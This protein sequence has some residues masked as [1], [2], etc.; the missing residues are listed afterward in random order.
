MLTTLNMQNATVVAW[1]RLT[2]P[3]TNYDLAANSDHLKTRTINLAEAMGT[4]DFDTN[5]QRDDEVWGISTLMSAGTVLNGG[6]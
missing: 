1:D 6:N 3:G 2:P 5:R 4:W